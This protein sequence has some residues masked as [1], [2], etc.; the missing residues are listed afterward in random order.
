MAYQV[1]RINDLEQFGELNT[2]YL[3]VD[4]AGIMPDVRVDKTFKINENLDRIIENDKV[5]T[6]LFYENQWLINGS[7]I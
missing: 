7:T 1:T 5:F 4:D 3:L 6:C 2:T